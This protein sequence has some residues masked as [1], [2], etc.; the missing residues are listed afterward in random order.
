M[1]APTTVRSVRRSRG[2]DISLS[3][4]GSVCRVREPFASLN[5]TDKFSQFSRPC[6]SGSGAQGCG[7]APAEK[8]RR[9]YTILTYTP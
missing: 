3:C 8:R 4:V 2:E 7:R 5:L 1:M 9:P 6:L